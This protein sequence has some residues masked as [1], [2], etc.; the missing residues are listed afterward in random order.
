MIGDVSKMYLP[1]VVVLALVISCAGMAYTV[2]GVIKSLEFERQ[3]TLA[4]FASIEAS[5]AKMQATLE[6][7]TACGQK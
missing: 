7:R 2:G 3:Q 4:R 1:I 5:I 6:S